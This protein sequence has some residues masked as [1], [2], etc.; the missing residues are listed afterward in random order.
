MSEF[1]YIA[2]SQSFPGIVKIGRTDF[3]ISK[4]MAQL[5]A[6]DYGPSNFDGDSEWTA[7]KF[8][9]VSN[10]VEAEKNLHEYFSK[11]RV[12]GKRELF[13]SDNPEQ[14]A[15]EAIK[16]TNGEFIVNTIDSFDLLVDIAQGITSVSG[17]NV[18]VAAFYPN[19]ISADIIEKKFKLIDYLDSQGANSESQIKKFL[20]KSSSLVLT[21]TFI[22][23]AVTALPFVAMGHGLRAAYKDSKAFFE[24]FKNFKK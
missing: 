24:E 19:K 20:F 6:Q 15:D 10:N 11:F 23:G 2:E 3:D 21:G 4:R 14:L 18:F 7:I 13:Y 22:F 16:I 8:F 17:L 9:T 5:S 1:I 12:E